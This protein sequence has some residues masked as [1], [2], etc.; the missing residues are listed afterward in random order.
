MTCPQAVTRQRSPISML[1]LRSIQG[2]P[3]PGSMRHARERYVS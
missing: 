2:Q 3:Y 1:D